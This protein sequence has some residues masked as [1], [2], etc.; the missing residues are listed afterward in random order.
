MTVIYRASKSSMGWHPSDKQIE[1]FHSEARFI[2]L[3]CTAEESDGDGA[4]PDGAEIAETIV[5]FSMFRF[6]YEEGEM[7]LYWSVACQPR[8]CF[9]V[10][11]V[12]IATKYRLQKTRDDW[13]W[14]TFSSSSLNI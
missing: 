14:D 13:A 5:G 2:I 7:L 4:L 1:L 11:V 10:D 6:D 3:S 12:L 8:C 9:I